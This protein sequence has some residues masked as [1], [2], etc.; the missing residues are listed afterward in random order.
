MR[1]LILSLLICIAL[2]AVAQ[3]V[4]SYIKQGNQHYRQA[5]F[6]L[7]EAQYRLALRE[8]PSSKEAKFNLAN[9][10]HQQKKYDQASQLL[11]QLQTTEKDSFTKSISAYNQGVGY[12]KQKKLEESIEKYKQA[13]RMVPDDQ[14]AREN[15][16]KALRELKKQ[17]GGG[18]QQNQKS[19]MD[20]DEAD[21]KLKLLQ[22]KEKQIQQRVRKNSSGGS[23][24]KDW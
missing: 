21:Q 16:Q 5:Q 19:S 10:L 8:D 22:Q 23:Q 24:S 13:L 11:D 6:D 17:Q 12:T 3:S 20:Q 7:A 15:L 9:S 14:Q 2:A 1:V 18:G 4:N